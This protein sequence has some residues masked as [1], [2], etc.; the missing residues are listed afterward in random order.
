MNIKYLPYEK[1]GWEK[2][3]SWNASVDLSFWKADERGVQCLGKE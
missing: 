2:T 1:L 3:K